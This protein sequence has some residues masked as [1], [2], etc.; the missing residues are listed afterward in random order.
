[1]R[2]RFWVVLLPNTHSSGQVRG[3]SPD[4][5]LR[6]KPSQAVAGLVVE[7]ELD[8]DE[9]WFSPKVS[10]SLPAP[11]SVGITIGVD[12]DEDY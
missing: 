6:S 1:M 9:A 8:V 5:L 4:R 2:T 11:S 10:A 7:V 12:D 3:I